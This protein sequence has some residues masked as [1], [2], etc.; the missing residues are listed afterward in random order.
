MII[1]HVSQHEFWMYLMLMLHN[2]GT[3]SR[4]LCLN[5]LKITKVCRFK[6]IIKC[7]SNVIYIV[8]NIVTSFYP[9]ISRL[10]SED[11]LKFFLCLDILFLTYS[12]ESSHLEVKKNAENFPNILEYSWFF[13]LF[14][15]FSYKNFQAQRRT[16]TCYASWDSP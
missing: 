16:N 10:N 13:P 9:S 2:K 12:H 8:N 4:K 14:R 5:Y 11:F 7:I 3:K 15:G 6:R 1:Q